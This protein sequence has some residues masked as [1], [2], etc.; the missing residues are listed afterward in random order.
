VVRFVLIRRSSFVQQLSVRG[1]NS[2]AESKTKL[3]LLMIKPEYSNA[4]FLG[5]LDLPLDVSSK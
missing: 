1:P 3:L 5:Y 2:A 4:Y